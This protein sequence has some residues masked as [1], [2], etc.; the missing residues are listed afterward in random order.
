MPPKV[1]DEKCNGC[2][3]CIYECGGFCLALN[4]KKEKIWLSNGRDC[5]DCF[6]CEASCPEEAIE[7]Q[8]RMKKQRKLLTA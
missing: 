7:I 8:P 2:G 6:R 4:P 5:V 1:S 3:I